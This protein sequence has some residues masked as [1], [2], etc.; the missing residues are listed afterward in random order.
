MTGN[1]TNNTDSTLATYLSAAGEFFTAD[2]WVALAYGTR[3][4]V[5]DLQRM[6]RE[7]VDGASRELV[8]EAR[9][10]RTELDSALLVHAA[11]SADSGRK[12]FEQIKSSQN[13]SIQHLSRRL[14]EV[15][16]TH[17]GVR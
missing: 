16:E 1:T 15:L 12:I 9:R 8:A 7:Q 5:T 6:E 10:A 11:E 4:R 13:R 2:Q 3:A 14:K 17:G